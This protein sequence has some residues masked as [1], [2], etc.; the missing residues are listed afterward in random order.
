MAIFI[1]GGRE[2][3]RDNGIN[4]GMEGRRSKKQG[5]DACSV[6]YAFLRVIWS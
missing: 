3:G 1:E 6:S 4:G 2:G 5:R